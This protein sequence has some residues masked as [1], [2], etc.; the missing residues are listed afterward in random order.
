MT[1]TAAQIEARAGEALQFLADT[2]E[3]A[4]ELKTETERALFRY[5]SHANAHFLAISGSVEERKRAAEREC[6]PLY[7]DYLEAMRK[8]EGLA[9]QRRSR[10]LEIE[11]ARSLYANY[12]HG[13]M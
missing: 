10:A 5:K 6:E 2:D 8:S 3:L 7:S 9:N 1:D 13:K 12:R 11:W 4:A